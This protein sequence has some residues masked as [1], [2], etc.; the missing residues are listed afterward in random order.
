[1]LDL[2]DRDDLRAKLRENT[3]C[4]R[5]RMTGSASTLP[6]DHP[7]VPIMLGDA[8]LADRMADRLLRKVS[9]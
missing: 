9:T 4:F 6:G 2:L 1:M 7:I 8:A 5:Q 3:A